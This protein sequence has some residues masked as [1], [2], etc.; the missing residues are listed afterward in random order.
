MRI[1]SS[2]PRPADENL[3]LR[4]NSRIRA[5][6]RDSLPDLGGPRVCLWCVANAPSSRDRPA[7]NPATPDAGFSLPSELSD[8]LSWLEVLS[9][10]VGSFIFPSWTCVGGLTTRLAFNGLWPLVLMIAVASALLAHAAVRKSSLR[11]AMLRGLEASI[12]ISFCVL[13]SVTRSLFLA[14]QCESFGFDD[15]AG[16]DSK[17]YLTASLNVECTGDGEHGSIIALAVVFVVLW[18]VAMPLLY[19]V[20]L[21]RCRHAIVDHQ[22]NALSRATRFLWS[23]CPCMHIEPRTDLH[24]E[25]TLSDRCTDED[26][27]CG[28]E[29]VVIVQKLVLTNV[30]LFFNISGGSDQILRLIV[31]L[32]VTLL[33]LTLQ[34]L[35]QPF[36]KPSDDALNCVVQLVLVLFFTLGIM[37]KLCDTGASCTALVGVSSAYDASVVMICAGLLVLLIPIGMFVRQLL[38][39]R[40]VAILRD[41][42][43]MEPPILLLGKDERYHLFL[44]A[45]SHDKP[46]SSATP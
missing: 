43:T 8:W 30:V 39:A 19:A 31:G 14:F 2:N 13:P 38:F 32:L 42:S 37:V 24:V 20:L 23:E 6:Y 12:L 7:A 22:P 1:C 44:C 15:I 17:A 34:L 26:L 18:P 45:I 29:M 28:Y 3:H 40:A 27:Y 16:E 10:D 36:R 35:T 25:L 46:F 4:R 21:H 33:G 9:F 41:A 11:A 5:P